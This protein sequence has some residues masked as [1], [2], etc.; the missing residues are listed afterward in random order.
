M[1]IP[2]KILNGFHQFLSQSPFKVSCIQFST[3]THGN[4]PKS[5]LIIPIRIIHME[6]IKVFDNS[7]S[8]LCN[9]RIEL[10]SIHD[11]AIVF[12]A[13]RLACS[14]MTW[15]IIEGHQSCHIIIRGQLLVFQYIFPFFY[16]DTQLT[17]KGTLRA[18]Y[19]VNLFH[20]S[21]FFNSCKDSQCFPMIQC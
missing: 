4:W 2:S 19:G 21:T 5:L 9:P 8:K 18:F 6:T 3:L 20:F 16:G 13:E 7:L 14:L 17:R 1:I 15:F 10:L 12:H 11:I